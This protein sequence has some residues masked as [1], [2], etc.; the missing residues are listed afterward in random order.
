MTQKWI[1]NGPYFWVTKY[2]QKQTTPPTT[3]QIWND[4]LKSGA[5]DIFPSKTFLKHTVMK[6]MHSL[7]NLKKT[8]SPYQPYARPI[9]NGWELVTDN[10]FKY[11]HPNLRDLNTESQESEIIIN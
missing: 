6:N 5:T 7:G 2:I 11:I 9:K 4:I 10:A 8:Y 1:T 3:L